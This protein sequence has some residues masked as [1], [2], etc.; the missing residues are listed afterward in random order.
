MREHDRLFL[1]YD[2]IATGSLEDTMKRVRS[3]QLSLGWDAR[4]HIAVG[5]VK[6]LRYLHF[7]CSSR[8][9]HYRLKPGNVMLDEGFEPMLTDCGLRGM[10][11]ARID[12]LTC[13]CYAA[14]ECFQSCRYIFRTLLLLIFSTDIP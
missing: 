4:H 12:A 8:I 3:G 14:P 1:V 6:G 9:L 10:V 2:Y 13:D 11:P 5:I 7:E